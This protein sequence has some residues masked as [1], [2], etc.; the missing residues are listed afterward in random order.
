MINAQSHTEL[1]DA[2][3]CL[4]RKNRSILAI[5][6]TYGASSIQTTK[7][8]LTHHKVYSKAR[9]TMAFESSSLIAD[10]YR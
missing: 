2:E 3:Y 7:R 6:F 5:G 8:L 9:A 4:E 10:N 1:L